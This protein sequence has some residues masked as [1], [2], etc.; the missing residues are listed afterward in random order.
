M[1][2]KLVRQ[3]GNEPKSLSINGICANS[4]YCP[5]YDCISTAIVICNI[6]RDGGIIWLA[7]GRT[8]FQASPDL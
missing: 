3:R 2:T 8:G 4:Y 7:G 6:I 5:F 1:I